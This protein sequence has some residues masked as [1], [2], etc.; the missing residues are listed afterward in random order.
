MTSYEQQNEE[1]AWLYY[2]PQM[3][4]EEL[5]AEEREQERSNLE[6]EADASSSDNESFSDLPSRPGQVAKIEYEYI[7]HG[8]T[9]L[10]GNLHVATGKV[11]VPLLRETRTELD[12]LENLDNIICTDPDA[13]FR[14][15]VDNL[16]T[17]ASESC[18]R[19]VAAS[20]GIDTDLG[21]K[22]KHGILQSVRSRMEFLSDATHRIRFLY[23]PRH[24][25]WLNQIEIWFGVLRRK[26]TRRG[27]FTSIDHLEHKI[28]EFIDYYNIT[29]ARPYRWTYNG[30]VLAK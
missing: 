8:T 15:I 11:I 5:E 4:A 19:Y 25:S 29:M 1:T 9:G 3:T 30:A 26:Q 17:H 7:R 27:S 20:C 23:V 13:P 22:G 24:T 12:F 2:L 14:L 28:R 16:N 6:A 10:F 21:V 18:V